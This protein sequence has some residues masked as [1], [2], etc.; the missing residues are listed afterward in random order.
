MSEFKRRGSY[1]EAS[2]ATLF[3][4]AGFDIELNCNV[5]GY[6]VDVYAKKLP[7]KYIIECKHYENS[8]I[9]VRNIIHQWH[10][11]N[12]IIKADKVVIVIAGQTPTE[13]DYK[14]A[15]RLD[16]VLLSEDKLHK[17][18]ELPNNKLLLKIGKLLDL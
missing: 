16:M 4:R 13:E 9:N 17:L 5:K 18:S 8:K 14:L 11:K 1:L 12:S 3:K 15:E 7:Y 2:V 6:E 10:S